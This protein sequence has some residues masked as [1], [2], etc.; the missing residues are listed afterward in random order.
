VAS[1]AST[2]ARKVTGRKRCILVDTLA[3]LLVVSAFAADI[4]AA[5]GAACFPRIRQLWADGAFAGWFVSWCQHVLQWVVTIPSRSTGQ[6]G[7]VVLPR[8]W[9]AE[10]SLAWLSRPRRLAKDYEELPECAE[11]QVYIASITLLLNRL[12]PPRC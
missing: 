6:R 9:A 5:A 4:P 11:A 12:I 3:L 1:E 7:F 2:G 10:R 8:R